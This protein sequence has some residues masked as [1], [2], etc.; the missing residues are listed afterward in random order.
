MKKF[1]SVILSLLITFACIIAV[2]FSVSATQYNDGYYTYTIYNDTATIVYCDTSIIGAITIPSTLG[3]YSVTSIGYYAF[4]GCKTLTNITIPRSVTSIGK[5]AFKDCES[6]TSITIP[7]SVTSIGVNAFIGCTSLKRVNITDLAAWCKINFDISNALYKCSNPLYYAKNLYINGVLA[8]DITIPD[9]VTKI[10]S[11]AFYNCDS[12]TSVIIPDSVTIINSYTFYDCDSLTS[13]TLPE[14]ITSIGNS[15]FYSCGLT[16]VTIPDSVTNIDSYAF[17]ACSL[18]S[19]T[20]PDQCN[21]GSYAFNDCRKLKNVTFVDCIVAADSITIGSYAFYNCDSL[22]SIT[23]S[24]SVTSIGSYA[25]AYCDYLGSITIPPSV[26]SIGE[27]AF[28]YCGLLYNIY[29]TDISKWCNIIFSDNYAPFTTSI[30][31][32][33]Y[34][35]KRLHVNN[36]LLTDLEI[37]DDMQII[38]AYQFYNCDSIEKIYIPKS[39]VL[40]RKNA[41][42]ACQN[43][44]TI[45][46]EGTAEEW[47]MIA[48]L[49]GNDKINDATVF[50]NSSGI[51]EQV[52]SDLDGDGIIGASDI[53]IMRRALLF[54]SDNDLTY[55]ISGDGKFNIID[56]I[57]LKKI[58]VKT[59]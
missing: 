4:K 8:T 25:F 45:Y 42:F 57:C 26:T 9:S 22:T 21:V 31:S 7:K 48:K 13:I 56:L 24:D 1:L 30:Y 2:P 44:D 20:I 14:S 19:V 46:Y 28:A 5:E 17:C 47:E 11:L 39:V 52:D 32:T 18:T 38:G 29:I 6:L 16:S 50:Y 12:L 53:V 51:P 59:V 10:S 58:V 41:F 34:G 54:S 40:I 33:C 37:P 3:G 27:C 49:E 43:I 35:T 36:Q 23:L 15:A 55:D